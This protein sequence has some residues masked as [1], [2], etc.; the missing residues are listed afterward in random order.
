MDITDNFSVFEI[1]PLFEGISL[2]IPDE[3]HFWLF[4]LNFYICK[5]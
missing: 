1:G 5:N 4:L 3:K 2:E